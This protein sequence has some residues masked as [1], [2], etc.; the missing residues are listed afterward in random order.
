[1]S[2]P[3]V[4]VEIEPDLIAAAT[5]EAGA[6]TSERVQA[7]VAD[8]APCRDDFA[9]YR[10]VDAVVSTLRG[11]TP[12]GE[13]GE[14][15]R[16]RL[17]AR[18]ADLR[19][20]L[21]SYRVFPSP[22]GPILLAASEH[23]VAL[24]EYLGREGVRGSRLFRAEDVETREDGGALERLH[25]E[26]LDYLAGRRT[27]LE[28]PLDLR[29]ARSDFERAVLRATAAVPY[30]AVSSY[31]GIAG[32]VGKPSAVRAVAQALRHNPVPIVV[33]CHRIVGVGG[34]LVGYAGNRVNLKEHLLAVEGVP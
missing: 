5:G 17:L 7:H 2:K 22:L 6:R 31:T 27:R 28:W 20:R 13:D 14:A 4:C 9:R 8:C 12:A 26:L 25:G 32:E 15:A 3:R 33:P 34:D 24:V 1:M 30:G 29:F 11:R 16:Q 18:L 21:V 10:A 23:G 19:S